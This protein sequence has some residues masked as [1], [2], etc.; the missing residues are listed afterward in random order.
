M[1]HQAALHEALDSLLR[2]E[3]LAP[4][5]APLVA[6]FRR[7][8]DGDEEDFADAVHEL[9]RAAALR[10]E[11]HISELL[12]L[13]QAG[14]VRLTQ[15]NASD[16]MGRRLEELSVTALRCA[17]LGYTAGLEQKLAAL[18]GLVAG[19]S[20]VDPKTGAL[21][22]RDLNEH[23][24]LEISRCQRMQLPLGLAA[25]FGPAPA[26]GEP[27]GRLTAGVGH[28]LREN[29][30][31]YDDLGCLETGE[32]VAVLPDAS[33]SGLA[34][35]A[36]RLHSRLAEDPRTAGIPHRMALTHFDCVDVTVVDLLE[37]LAEALQHARA[38]D[39]YISWT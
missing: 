26:A 17:A 24:S 6:P 10:G 15:P 4:C 9:A 38:G 12:S 11:P 30:R 36:E 34:A 22:P 2:D 31:R 35:A 16:E 33:R 29:L 39:D 14:F 20:P 8:L 37:Q 3:R 1:H 21:R 7:I 32:F 13:L 5:W 25:V 19:A 23:L 18:E 28:V 27:A